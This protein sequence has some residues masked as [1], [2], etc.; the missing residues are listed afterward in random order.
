MYALEGL[1]KCTGATIVLLTCQVLSP[2][3]KLSAEPG[4]GLVSVSGA[5]TAGVTAKVSL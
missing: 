4:S 1:V 5:T 3:S 2:A